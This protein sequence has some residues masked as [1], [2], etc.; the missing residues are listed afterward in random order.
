MKFIAT[1]PS[2]VRDRARQSSAH[3]SFFLSKCL[4]AGLLYTLPHTALM[5]ETGVHPWLDRGDQLTAT[6]KVDG[7]VVCQIRD[8]VAPHDGM[9]REP[10]CVFAMPANATTAVLTGS[11]KRHGVKKPVAFNR[12][13]N[14]VDAAPYTQA[15]YDPQ[16]SLGQRWLNWSKQL[17]GFQKKH[18]AE[19]F[20]GF[21]AKQGP[22]IATE[23]AAAE[24]RLRMPLAA[25][26]KEVLRLQIEA[27]D[28][29]FHRPKELVTV[30]QMLLGD[31]DYKSLD[32]ILPPAV[33]ARYRR[34]VAVFTE[35]GDGLG[36]LAFDPQGVQTGEPSNAWGDQHGAGAQ[37]SLP[38]RGVWFWIHQDS[39]DQPTLL[40]TRERQAASDEQALLSVLQRF[41][42]SSVLDSVVIAGW[43]AP[44]DDEK[45]IWVD[46][47]HPRSLMQLHFDGKK[48]KLWLRSYD[49][50]YS[51]LAL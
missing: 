8:E 11:L 27:G 20:S 41:E 19:Y 10:S 24:K 40:L 6:L 13:W 21:R 9:R 5:A 23:I 46:S 51:L 25:A 7:K 31:W 49:H 43:V 14:V 3:L 2:F 12:K 18:P 17:D 36:A 4:A 28:S 35:V 29:R 38:P 50:F 42:V 47:A 22:A 44:V 32:K 39:I 26:F 16:A 48:P 45:T 15:L 30:E 33:L 34:S 37:L 1:V